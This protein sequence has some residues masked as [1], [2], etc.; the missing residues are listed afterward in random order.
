MPFSYIL[1][2]VPSNIVMKKIKPDVRRLL[3]FRANFLHRHLIIQHASVGFP[4]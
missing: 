1:V 2:E 3:V 4:S